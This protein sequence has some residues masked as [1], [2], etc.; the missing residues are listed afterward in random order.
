M[1]EPGDSEQ[2]ERE[3]AALEAVAPGSPGS[4]SLL[5]A[6]ILGMGAT[7]IVGLLGVAR[8][9]V[10]AVELEP[11]GLGLYGQ[12]LTLLTALGAASGLGL[13]LGTTRVVA[14][15]RAR[16]DRDGLR[17]A[18]EVSFA[19]PL[20]FGVVLG[21][22]LIA[23][24]GALASLLLDDDRA[25]LDGVR[26][27]GRAARGAPGP[28]RPRAPGLQRRG[29]RAGGERLLRGRC[30]RSPPWRACWSP[31]STA[32][33]W[34]SPPR[35]SIYAGALAWRLRRL[36]RSGGRDARA[37]RGAPAQPPARAGDPDDARDRL[38]L[39]V[40]GRGVMGARARGAD[41]P[42]EAAR[43][44]GRRRD[45]P[46]AS[47]DLRAAAGGD[48]G[49][50]SCSSASRRSPRRTRWATGRSCDARSTTRCGSR[51]CS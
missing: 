22:M 1:T 10:L 8:T 15:S 39:G 11:A 21:L 50:R 51:S 37:A 13:G 44:G 18:L 45:L 28:A 9:K 6:A 31:G 4:N 34:R 26:R 38:R 33:S 3:Y 30:S 20:A 47:A 46:G 41:L 27:T 49:R 43:R 17:V 32:P 24:S 40:R 14:E 35:T 25:L 19:L 23:G 16:D 5:D 7:V 12:M 2:A 48:R 29:G 42:A 36:L